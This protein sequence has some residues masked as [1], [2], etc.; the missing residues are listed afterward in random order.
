M[1]TIISFGDYVKGELLTFLPIER[2]TG[3]KP[4]I[5]SIENDVLK[6]YNINLDDVGVDQNGSAKKGGMY[7][8]A[9]TYPAYISLPTQIGDTT[10]IQVLTGILFQRTELLNMFENF[11][12]QND[13]LRDSVTVLRTE[14]SWFKQ[15]N[16]K[17]TNQKFSLL[18]DLRE[19]KNKIVGS[20][21]QE[22]EDE[23][24]K[25]GDKND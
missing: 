3:I 4:I 25:E 11:A 1:S 14:L 19:A 8:K 7:F 18:E 9:L 16:R 15:E 5:V 24:I 13:R 22:D 10:V 6:L 23:S 12:L 21:S 20:V 2:A 17:L